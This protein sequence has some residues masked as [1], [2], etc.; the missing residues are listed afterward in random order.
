M[1]VY[2]LFGNDTTSEQVDYLE[3]A[4]TTPPNSTFNVPFL[5]SSALIEQNAFTQHI[6]ALIKFLQ[7]ILVPKP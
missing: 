2:L 7:H 1:P 6:T 4:N 3:F 5:C